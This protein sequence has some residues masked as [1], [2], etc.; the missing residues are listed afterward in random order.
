M[1]DAA[2]K[3]AFQRTLM[4]GQVCLAPDYV[5]V[6]TAQRDEFVAALAKS[7]TA[8]YDPAGAGPKASADFPRIINV[9]HTR[10]I[11]GLLE[12]AKKNVVTQKPVY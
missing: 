2:H 6:P 5:L 3:L 10:R 9:H 7:M 4:A 12:D 11:I 1:A 8:M